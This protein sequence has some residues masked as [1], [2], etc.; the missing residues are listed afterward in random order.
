MGAACRLASVDSALEIVVHLGNLAHEV[1][2]GELAQ[3]LGVGECDIYGAF[4]LEG[5][6]DF[7]LALYNRLRDEDWSG[8]LVAPLDQPMDQDWGDVVELPGGEL[9]TQEQ[10]LEYLD[11]GSERGQPAMTDWRLP[12]RNLVMRMPPELFARLRSVVDDG[13]T[14]RRLVEVREAPIDD[15]LVQRLEVLNPGDLRSLPLS[16][17]RV[18]N[19]VGLIRPGTDTQRSAPTWD[20]GTSRG[21]RPMQHRGTL[22]VRA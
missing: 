4:E 12:D 16:A 22:I 5:N 17:G 10:L 3:M 2:L 19:E 7:V 8:Q 9:L 18:E 1:T 15:S 14:R 6:W 13:P 20:G 21:R 11:L